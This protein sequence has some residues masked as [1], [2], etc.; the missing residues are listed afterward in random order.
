MDDDSWLQLT[1]RE[2][3][4]VLEA[5]QSMLRAAPANNSEVENLALKLALANRHPDVTVGVYGGLVQWIAGN[6]FPIRVCD[7]DGFDLPNVDERGRPCEIRYEQPNLE[8]VPD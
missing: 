7:Y 6:P 4:I 2:H 1:A 8:G 3:A 5:V